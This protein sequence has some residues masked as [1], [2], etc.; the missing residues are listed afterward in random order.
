M[1][2]SGTALSLTPGA[3][4]IFE[5][6]KDELCKST[7][8]LFTTLILLEWLAMI[9]VSIIVS[10]LAWE[11]RNSYIHPHILVAIFLGG[12]IVLPVVYF[13]ITTPGKPITRHVIAFSQTLI[14]AL[15]IHLT[16]GRIE[17]HFHI[18][19]SLAF[20]AFYRDWRVFITAVTVV[21]L[22]HM[23]RGIF[24]PESVYGV[25]TASPWRTVEHAGWVLFESFFLVKVCRQNEREMMTLASQQD[26]LETTN[27]RIQE[28]A[29]K[30]AKELARSQSL[31]AAIVNNSFDAIVGIN[32]EYKITSWNRGAESLYGYNPE[33]INEKLV[34]ILIPE[35]LQADFYKRIDR[36][37]EGESMSDIETLRLKADGTVIDVALT[38][39]P[40]KNSEDEIIGCSLIERDITNR[41]ELEKRISEFYSTVSHEL[42]TPLTSIRGALSI[43]DDEIVEL[44][45]EEAREMVQLARSS[46]ERLVR[47]INDILDL[48][49]IE[50]GKLELHLEK[51]D[52]C[53]LLKN[54]IETMRG[55]A[56]KAE[57]TIST[58][59]SLNAEVEVD[60]DR[61]IQ[62]LS[63]LIS[64]AIKYSPPN[65]M[66]LVSVDSLEN[67]R[68]RF[69]VTDEG[70]GIAPEN[71]DKLFGKFQQID[72][73]DTRPKEGTGLGLAICK[74]IVEQHNGTIGVHS[75]PGIGSTFWFELAYEKEWSD[76]TGNKDDND[77]GPGDGNGN[78]NGNNTGDTD[79][80]LL[81]EDD[82][83]LAQLLKLCLKKRGFVSRHVTNIAEA[84]RY[85]KTG[86]PAVI[87]SDV[88]LPDGNGIDYLETIKSKPEL[89]KIPVIIISGRDKEEFEFAHPFIYSWF[90]KPFELDDLTDAVTALLNGKRKVLVIED[91]DETRAVITTQLSKK[92]NAV[93]LEAADGKN[94]ID[95][96]V[97]NNPDVIVLD[98]GLPQKDGYEVVKALSGKP[99]PALLVYSGLDLSREERE[100]L[101]LGITRHLTKG[102]ISPKEFVA[103]VE[104][105][106]EG[107]KRIGN[108]E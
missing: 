64:N 59:V 96:A 35:D 54:G 58:N 69:S 61:M 38:V 91:D 52:A 76:Q 99:P 36:V 14:S 68:V 37:F 45:S 48:R 74:A 53:K 78:G 102:R 46:S 34:T 10:P 7:D 16:G 25:F 30:R 6:R 105:L 42:R 41:K 87:I 80:I 2:K 103:T 90:H 94:A 60:P 56:Q 71:L 28:L 15:L 31:L 82:L 19:G 100:K 44:D 75:R 65:G 104:E 67:G 29:E 92:I 77:T 73:S 72:S 5:R 17:T 23:I 18:F 33:D 11:G 79:M 4:A 84:T 55:M 40:I 50:A 1:D 43:I 88:M 9:I 62:V 24:I 32:R 89:A 47:L 27:D 86:R 81:I 57:V 22:D 39:S 20:L 97:S 12:L 26:E 108:T 95:I 21:T 63:N 85:L 98:I 107:V 101:K 3:R 106:L 49:K 66:I 13:Y 93:C 83:N 51:T 8:R 70:E